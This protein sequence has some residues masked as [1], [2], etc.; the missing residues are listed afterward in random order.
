MKQFKTHDLTTLN[1]PYNSNK[2][3]TFIPIQEDTEVAGKARN[4]QATTAKF[5]YS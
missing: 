1:L 4:F 2:H 3:N 5:G